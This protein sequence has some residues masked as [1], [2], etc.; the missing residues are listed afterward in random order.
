MAVEEE[1]EEDN[2]PEDAPDDEL[3][4]EEEETEDLDLT[5]TGE[6]SANGV[7]NDSE[8]GARPAF[9]E[10]DAEGNDEPSVATDNEGEE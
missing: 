10:E 2:T 9:G 3:D 7:N 6:L 5:E 1:V 8:N 4:A